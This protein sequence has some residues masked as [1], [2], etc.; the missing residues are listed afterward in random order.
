MPDSLD[1]L[2][3]L[4]ITVPADLGARFRGIRFLDGRSTVR[5]D[6]PRGVGIA[7]R[8]IALH[9]LLV[10]RAEECNVKFRGAPNMCGWP[11]RESRSTAA[12]QLRN[13]S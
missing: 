13:L 11:T 4:G 7:I 5:A 3:R 12:S 8:R 6:F 1:V 9:E 10:K 2:E